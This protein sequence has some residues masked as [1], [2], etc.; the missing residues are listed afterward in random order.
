MATLLES[1][2]QDGQNLLCSDCEQRE[3]LQAPFPRDFGDTSL[4][5]ARVFVGRVM[6]RR[7][8]R[9]M[10]KSDGC[11]ILGREICLE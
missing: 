11:C 2:E 5:W 6:K 8:S 3:M 4:E 10:R 9:R 1:S 7:V